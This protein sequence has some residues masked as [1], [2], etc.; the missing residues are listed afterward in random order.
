MK[1]DREKCLAAGATDY[2]P[3]PV[4]PGRLLAA[5]ESHLAGAA[6]ADPQG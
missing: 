4:D 2:I 5:M 6:P 1:G 3:K